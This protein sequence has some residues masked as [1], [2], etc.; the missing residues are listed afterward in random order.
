MHETFFRKFFIVAKLFPGKQFCTKNFHKKFR[1]QIFFMVAKYFPRKLVS[2]EN[3]YQKFKVQNFLWLQNLFLENWLA[4]KI[5]IKNSW[6][7]NFKSCKIISSKTVL[8]L[9]RSS[10]IFRQKFFMI[11]KSFPQKQVCTE[12]FYHKCFGRKFV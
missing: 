6:L 5:F 4:L 9:K 8:H 2:T 7:K 1:V 10:N 3:F 11:A 12:N